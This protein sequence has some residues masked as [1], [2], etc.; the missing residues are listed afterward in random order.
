MEIQTILEKTFFAKF[1]SSCFSEELL[2]NSILGIKYLFGLQ[3]KTN[4]NEVPHP[5]E[6]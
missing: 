5:P 4:T 2:E 1:A 3:C 6:K